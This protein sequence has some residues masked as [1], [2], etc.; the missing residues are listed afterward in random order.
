MQ[1]SL[2]ANFFYANQTQSRFS[3]KHYATRA[4]AAGGQRKEG[5]DPF[6]GFYEKSYIILNNYDTI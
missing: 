1:N 5:E 2:F 3:A 4:D 6:E